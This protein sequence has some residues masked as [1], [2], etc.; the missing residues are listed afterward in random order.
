M[1]R[2]TLKDRKKTVVF[3]AILLISFFLITVNIKRSPQ[4]TFLEKAILW[5]IAPIQSVVTQATRAVA[6]VFDHYVLLVNTSKENEDLKRRINELMKEKTLLEEEVKRLNRIYNLTQYQQEHDVKSVVATVI[7]F[8]ASQWAKTIVINKG[9]NDGL[10]ENLPVVTDQGVVGHTIQVGF[11][12]AK[13]M[14]VTDSRSAID[15]L[16]QGDRVSGVVVG[17][18]EDHCEM[19]YVPISAPVEVGDVVLSSGLG[20]IFPKGLRLGT[21]I[22]VQKATQGLFQEVTIIPSADLSRLEEVLVLL[23]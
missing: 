12:S 18:G 23:M 1:L 8:D 5:V 21:V 20:G 16:F 13:I 3:I 11:N 4:P 22:Q 6:D 14:L 17:T 10:R 2:Q 19:K 15:A 7:G 9:T